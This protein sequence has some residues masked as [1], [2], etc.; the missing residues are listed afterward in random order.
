M[1]ACIYQ[2][3]SVKL[4]YYCGFLILKILYYLYLQSYLNLAE[5]LNFQNY[6]KK[7]LLSLRPPV[8]FWKLAIF[9]FYLEIVNMQ[10]NVLQV[11][12]WIECTIFRF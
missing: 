9:H 2:G 5:K 8:L 3:L 4:F 10:S 6:R 7:L 11:G 12:W 1:H